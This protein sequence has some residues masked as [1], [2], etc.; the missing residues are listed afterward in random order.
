MTRAAARAVPFGPPPAGMPSVTFAGKAF[1]S[2]RVP[3]LKIERSLLDLH[4]RVAA[5]TL[6]LDRPFRPGLI[7]P[8]DIQARLVESVLLRLPLPPVH[9][10]EARDGSMRI[11]DG[12]QRLSSLFAFLEG[13]LP[14]TGL[15]F[16]PELEG[17][18]FPALP[19]RMRRRYEDASLTVMILGSD[20]PA[21]LVADVF[22][23][24]NAWAPLRDGEL[25]GGG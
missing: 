24:M 1:E 11:I 21:E 6:D 18:R 22:D 14:L 4:R 16:L 3:I 9:V 5:G 12:L 23:R 8:Q 19:I 10:A 25:P 13:K 15:R 17:K 2:R 20:A 7:W